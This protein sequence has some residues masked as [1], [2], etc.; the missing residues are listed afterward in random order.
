M[1]H[2]TDMKEKS[3]DPAHIVIGMSLRHEMGGIQRTPFTHAIIVSC[4][5]PRATPEDYFSL[6]AGG[7]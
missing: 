2:V 7:K 1:P 3:I 4:A 6:N 5:D